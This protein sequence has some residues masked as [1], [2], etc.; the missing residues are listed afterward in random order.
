MKVEHRNALVVAI[1][2]AVVYALVLAWGKV[3]PRY[4]CILLMG[5][6][7]GI[8]RVLRDVPRRIRTIGIHAVAQVLILSFLVHLWTIGY[9]GRNA[10]F[11]GII[12]WSDS[13]DYLDDSLRLVHGER[14]TEFS[15]KRPIF[16]V[17]L[18][19]L[20]KASWGSLRFAL[21]VCAVVGA[22]AVALGALEVWKTHGVR[23]AFVVFIV[24]LFFERRWTGFIQT[25]HIGLPLGVI[26]FALFWR[27]HDCREADPARAKRLVLLGLFALSTGLMARAGAF[28]VIPA[29]GIW[30][31]RTLETERAARLRFLG[32]CAAA[33]IFGFALH[34]TILFATGSGVTFSDYPGIAYGLLHGE[35]YTY[36]TQTHPELA[37]M[38][39]GQRVPASW[40]IVSAEAASHPQLVVI[41]FAKSF[42]GLFISPF[43]M[44]SYIWTNP[45]DHIMEH[46]GTIGLWLKELGIY[47][48]VNAGVMGLMGGLFVL[49]TIYSLYVL[50][51]KRRGDDDLSLVRHAAI[52]VLV[53]APFTPPWITSGMQVQT[54]TM[55]F[56]AAIPAVILFAQEGD[57]PAVM[58]LPDRIRWVPVGF[59]AFLVLAVAWLR[60]GPVPAP[61]CDATTP[62]DLRPYWGTRVEVAPSRS[63]DPNR[64]AEADLRASL[65]FLDKHN[66]ELVKSIEP[67]LHPGTVYVTAFD[68]CDRR[69]KILV[70][71]HHTL[72]T[73]SSSFRTMDVVPLA[74]PKVLRL[75][76]QPPVEP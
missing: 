28:F 18:A 60:L 3:V 11:G 59:A 34:K 41:G 16:G 22:F 1:G 17:V 76:P 37:A 66:P 13:F 21:F 45:D 63:M 75:R 33:A 65:V 8:F 47:S 9:E 57:G 12:P 5:V 23:S 30:A 52:G 2:A 35:D 7:V 68:A 67:V 58:L 39:V 61:Y 19:F 74:T 44:F 6:L 69:A 53:S 51:W 49:G 40:S 50:L 54:V 27:A 25:E 14:F 73:T 36:L 71:D 38:S 56:V 24:L 10:V 20:L 64:I 55:A 72:D 48:L 62:H 70:D 15:S 42:A 31:A 29:L 26:G 4:D 46:G 43:G 32:Y